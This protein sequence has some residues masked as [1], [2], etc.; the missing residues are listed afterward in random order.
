[1]L[2]DPRG[3]PVTASDADSAARLEATIGAYCVFHK[4]TG[5]RL[6][7]A[8][9]GDPLLVMAHLLRGYFML[10][11][12]KRELMPRAQQA[13]EAAD[14]AMREAG[15]TPREAL[16]RQALAAWIARD[17]TKAIAILRSILAEYPRD[18]VALK[19]VQYLLFYSGDWVAM[20]DAVSG[21][22]E[23]WDQSLPGYSFALGCHAF[24]LEECGDYPAAERAGRRA[25]ELNPQDIWGAHAVAHVC[26]MQD[27]A[28]D[29]LDW[30]N[31]HESHWSET[32]NFAF[33]VWWHRCLF[34]M[35][36]RRFDEAL[37]RYDREVR[38]ESTDEYLDMTNA[39][40]LLWRLEQQG[41]DVGH[42]WDE[43]AARASARATEHMMSFGDAH[44]AMALA[45]A[46]KDGDF[47]RWL[48]SARAYAAQGRETQAAVLGTVGLALGEAALAHRQGD[49]TRALDRLLPMRDAIRRIGGSHAQRDLFAQLLIDSAVKSGRRGVAV[50]LLNERLS[51]RPRNSWGLAERNLVNAQV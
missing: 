47:E 50:E 32:N 45:A 48:A 34:L 8:L 42:R 51:S 15:S 4:Q 16:H 30:I 7:E 25:V 12:V 49:Y 21:A 19:L 43:L 44:Y 26:E 3:I 13:V 27:R 17:E 46:G 9:T 40:A 6:K 22:L 33:H 10:L 38:A 11:L 41:A 18:L 39:V 5:D 23:A 31:G 20:R 29:G 2:T 24:G 1:M 37:A 14:K 35:A 36:S 28:E